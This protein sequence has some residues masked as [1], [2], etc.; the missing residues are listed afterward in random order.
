MNKQWTR[1]ISHHDGSKMLDE[2]TFYDDG[3]CVTKA[4]FENGAVSYCGE[5]YSATITTGG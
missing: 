4:F 5:N 1:K 3:S 2:T